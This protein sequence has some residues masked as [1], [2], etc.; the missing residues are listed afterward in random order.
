[1]DLDAPLIAA[2][3]ARAALCAACIARPAGIS[4]S[5]VDATIRDVQRSLQVISI[6]ATCDG[7][8]AQRVLVHRL[9]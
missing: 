9:G 7:C 4:P 8:L 6:V 2:L 1:M 3:I 5:R